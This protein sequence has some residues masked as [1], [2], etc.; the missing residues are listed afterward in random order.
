MVGDSKGAQ[1]GFAGN[2]GG[3]GTQKYYSF[4]LTA[5]RAGGDFEASRAI[6]TADASAA[7]GIPVTQHDTGTEGSGVHDGSCL[8]AGMRR[9]RALLISRR[10]SRVMT[11]QARRVE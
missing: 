3:E 6:S 9:L 4:V 8:E 10:Q 2:E 7:G 5:W 11:Q 1:L